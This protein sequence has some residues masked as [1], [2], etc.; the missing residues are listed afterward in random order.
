MMTDRVQGTFNAEKQCCEETVVHL[1]FLNPESKIDNAVQ[2]AET[3]AT[4]RHYV[5]L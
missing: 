4:F 1:V 3:T 5:G 2:S